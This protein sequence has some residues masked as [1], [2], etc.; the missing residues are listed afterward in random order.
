MFI[1]C[2]RVDFQCGVIFTCLKFT[3]ANR[4]EAMHKR[5]VNVETFS[6]SFL[7]SALFILPLFY[8]RNHNLRA[9]TSVAKNA[10]VII[11]LKGRTGDAKFCSFLLRINLNHSIICYNNM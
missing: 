10:S 4:I 6:T 9:L 11:N 2:I 5:I 7:S 3:F 1:A 8:L